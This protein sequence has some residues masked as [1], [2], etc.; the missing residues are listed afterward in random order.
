MGAA[1]VAGERRFKPIYTDDQ[2]VCP[3]GLLIGLVQGGGSGC[4]C[5]IEQS[6]IAS[7]KDRSTLA[8]F[9]YGD[10]TRCPT[11]RQERER[12][13]AKPLIEQGD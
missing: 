11:W 4:R 12:R 8:S 1:R 5:R 2:P 7:T 10:Y 6:T 3:A 13:I 9:C